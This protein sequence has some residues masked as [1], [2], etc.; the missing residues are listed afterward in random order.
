M[1]RVELS[2]KRF[3][4]MASTWQHWINFILGLWVIVSG[5]ITF[6]SVS[7]ATNLTIIG[8]V[9]AVLALWGALENQS[10]QSPSRSAV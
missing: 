9:I 4:P 7:L 10:V 1:K 8:I 3:I 6:T 2:S 5:Y